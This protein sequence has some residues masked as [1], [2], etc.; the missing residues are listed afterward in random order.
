VGIKTFALW[1][2]EG[3]ADQLPSKRWRADWWG[4]GQTGRAGEEWRHAV[5]GGVTCLQGVDMLTNVRL[6]DK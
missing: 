1:N 5:N 3:G 6:N 2:R 4:G